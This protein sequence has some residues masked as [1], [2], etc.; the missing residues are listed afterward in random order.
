MNLT[1]EFW[2]MLIRNRL[3]VKRWRLKD[4]IHQ[5]L[6]LHQRGQT[7]LQSN[8]DHQMLKEGIDAIEPPNSKNV[9]L[10]KKGERGCSLY[11]LSSRDKAFWGPDKNVIE[12]L[13]RRTNRF[14]L[15]LLQGSPCYGYAFD[16]PPVSRWKL[17]GDG[18]SYKVNGPN[19]VQNSI[20][21]RLERDVVQFVNQLLESEISSQP[22]S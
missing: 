18:Y 22:G 16:P 8:A 9:R 17:G 7:T 4:L 2:N 13:S 20:A 11:V 1:D 5:L 21:I 19:D 15:I 14:G 3:E 6:K 12:S 10:I